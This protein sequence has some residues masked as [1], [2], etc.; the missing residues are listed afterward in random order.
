MLILTSLSFSRYLE[1][2]AQSSV[3]QGDVNLVA[4]R[5]LRDYRKGY[6][7]WFALE[8]PL[9]RAPVEEDTS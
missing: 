9:F 7:G 1:A 8:R 6:L 3:F 2:V 4:N 5:I